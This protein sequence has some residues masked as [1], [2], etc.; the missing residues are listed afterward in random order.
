MIDLSTIK[1]YSE[2]DS[3]KISVVVPTCNRPESLANLLFSILKQTKL[4]D[5]VLVVDD[6]DNTK[7]AELAKDLNNIFLSK[8]IVLRYLRG[9]NKN[10]S[11]SNAR[12]IGIDTSNGEIIF[13]ID[14]DVILE[15]HYIE[16]I[17][18]V[19]D[20]NPKAKG[21][22]GFIVNIPFNPSNIRHLIFNSI[23]KIFFLSHYEKNK[24][25]R[26]RGLC[27][28]YSPEGIIECEWLHGSNMS[29]RKEVITN[30]RFNDYFTLKGRSIGEDVR[31]S[32]KINFHFPHSLFMNP[33]AKVC[34]MHFSRKIDK[35]LIYSTTAYFIY[36]FISTHEPTI[37]NVILAF[38]NQF[39]RLIVNVISF[40]VSK[41]AN[42]LF[43]LIKSYIFA[44]KHFSD[45]KK[46]D[47]RF[48]N[49]LH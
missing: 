4:P 10:R 6:S 28:P 16:E 36:R 30:F 37:K 49:A 17:L 25:S 19:Y 23:N 27:Y 21:V 29:V 31:F 46:G 8:G 15:K 18:K 13:F 48:I 2:E 5:E 45:I 39:G 32:S 40:F 12:N 43:W 34:H 42:A 26:Q 38:W 35:Y 44:I 47:F 14:D 22:Q 41:N 7:T 1:S 11:I 20:I 24:C 9:D 3:L 33:K